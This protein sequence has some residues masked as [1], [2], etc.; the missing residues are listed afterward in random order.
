MLPA[1]PNAVRTA[2]VR[3]SLRSVATSPATVFDDLTNSAG[4]PLPTWGEG[5]GEGVTAP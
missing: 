5:W 1:E 4:L 2:V 3:T